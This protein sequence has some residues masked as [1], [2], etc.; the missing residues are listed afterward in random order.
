MS[1]NPHDG[2]D[3][4]ALTALETKAIALNS[5]ALSVPATNCAVATKLKTLFHPL[6]AKL[7]CFH[8]GAVKLLDP[9]VPW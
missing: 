1:A 3:H 8:V 2:S 5:S 4:A 7:F 6:T 9:A